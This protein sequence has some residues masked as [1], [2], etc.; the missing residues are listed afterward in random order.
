[1]ASDSPRNSL[2][3]EPKSKRKKASVKTSKEEA[4]SKQGTPQETSSSSKRPNRKEEAKPKQRTSR[5]PSSSSNRSNRAATEIPEVVSSRM[6]RRMVIFSGV[7]TALG[8]S[9]FF[10]SYF[11]LTRQIIDF[12]KYLVLLSTLGCFGLGV[13][14]LSYGALSASWD[15][16]RLGGWWGFSEFQ[17]NFSRLTGA[18]QTSRDKSSE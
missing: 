2:P 11:L 16:N 3:F 15:E 1:M 6:L 14:G 4:S 17:V 13:V 8:V 9:I 10:L 5:E 18:W 7:P 12:P